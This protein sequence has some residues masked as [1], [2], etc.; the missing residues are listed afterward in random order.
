MSG[1]GFEALI[2]IFIAILV[3]SAAVSPNILLILG[4]LFLL[5]WISCL[6]KT[7]W[8]DRQHSKYTKEYLNERR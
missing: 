6:I 4:S 7:A 5:G 1:S 2:F 8:D 3:I